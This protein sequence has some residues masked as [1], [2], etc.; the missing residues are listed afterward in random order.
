MTAITDHGNG[1]ASALH[2]AHPDQHLSQSHE[3]A[4]DVDHHRSLSPCPTPALRAIRPCPVPRA[5][6]LWARSPRHSPR[7]PPHSEPTRKLTQADSLECMRRTQV[8]QGPHL[9][10]HIPYDLCTP[11]RSVPPWQRRRRLVAVMH[12]IARRFMSHHPSASQSCNH[13]SLRYCYPTSDASIR[14]CLTL[15]VFT[16]ELRK[17][18][19]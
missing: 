4:P 1:S 19:R 3:F 16:P 12:A 9:L 18:G 15:R 5:P 11:S 14:L 10:T 8:I 13:P 7:T 17:S 6:S 2:P